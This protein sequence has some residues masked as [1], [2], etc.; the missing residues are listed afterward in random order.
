M[1][2]PSSV[3]FPDEA[4]IGKHLSGTK[5]NAV[6]TRRGKMQIDDLD[7]IAEHC[8]EMG[9]DYAPSDVFM[10]GGEGGVRL[11]EKVV[12]TLEKKKAS[13]KPLY[14]LDR[15][16]KEKIEAVA[17][18]IYGADGVDY[19][20]KAN[21]TIKQLEELGYGKLPVCIAKT[22]ASISDD[23]KKKG[24]PTGWR[25]MVREVNISGGAGFVVP[26]CGDMMLMP[27]LAKVPAAVHMD[28][29]KDGRIVGLK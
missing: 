6:Q 11:A 28:I 4:P 8:R 24:A 16:L 12:E 17:K 19:S 20:A 29:G 25:L 1:I 27:G 23:P 14:D 5:Q 21:A 15:P 3:G 22:Q 7:R 18:N 26:V 9:A 2:A 13:Y 10:N